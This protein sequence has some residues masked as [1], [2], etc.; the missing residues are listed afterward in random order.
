[1]LAAGIAIGV[2]MVATPAGAH[3]SSWAHNWN[4]HIKP[5]AD[6]RYVKKSAIRTIQGHY[7]GGGR[8]ATTSDYAWDQ[9]SFGFE[10]ASAPAEHFLPVGSPSTSQC[11]GTAGN[12]QAAPGH[13]CVYEAISD[14]RSDVIPFGATGTPSSASRW[15]AGLWFIPAAAGNFYSYGTWAVTA[16][17]GTSPK[18]VAPAAS[19]GS[20]A[21]E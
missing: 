10:L 9:I 8:A 15:G 12:P 17:A 4:K 13:L 1:L 19:T 21:G 7:A 18:R 20:T 6:K 14:N 5:K 3:V 2:V 11:P 16:P